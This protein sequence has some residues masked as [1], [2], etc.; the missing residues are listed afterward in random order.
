M[1][2]VATPLYITQHLKLL[3]YPMF[4]C[5]IGLH[6]LFLVHRIT[7]FPNITLNPWKLPVK[8]GSQRYAYN[9]YNRCAWK[10]NSNV[11]SWMHRII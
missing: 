1:Q 4:P 11:V 6:R 10:A 7:R 9:N 8:I 2:G 3:D 5:V